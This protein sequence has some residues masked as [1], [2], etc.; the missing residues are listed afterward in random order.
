MIASAKERGEEL[1]VSVMIGKDVLG[2]L[3]AVSRVDRATR[4]AMRL[5]LD[6]PLAHDHVRVVAIVGDQIRAASVEAE[7]TRELERAPVSASM[8][9]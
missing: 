2:L 4:A 5:W 3:L 8:L 9:N 6:G 7:P 1:V